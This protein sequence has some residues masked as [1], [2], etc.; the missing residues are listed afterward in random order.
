MS[1]KKS[2]HLL[3]YDS[4][5][6]LFYKRISCLSDYEHLGDH[7]PWAPYDRDVSGRFL[8][9]PLSDKDLVG[10]IAM[11]GDYCFDENLERALRLAS[12]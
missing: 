3:G 6:E 2:R 11:Y 9:V 1:L 7:E 5:K 10:S 12:S 4:S 8:Q